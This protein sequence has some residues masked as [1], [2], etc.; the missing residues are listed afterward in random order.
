M[1]SPRGWAVNAAVTS[2]AKAVRGNAGSDRSAPDAE[3]IRELVA[4]TAAESGDNGWGRSGV[5][6]VAE[7]RAIFGGAGADLRQLGRSR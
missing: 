3:R 5:A 6:K 2:D 7:Y 4:K 1:L